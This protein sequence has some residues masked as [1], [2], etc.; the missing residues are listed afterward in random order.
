LGDDGGKIYRSTNYG[1]NWTDLGAIASGA[2]YFVAYLGNGIVV[3]GDFNHHVF[4]ST[5]YGAN[6]TDLGVI[7]SDYINV[8][9][10]MGNGIAVLADHAHHVYRSTNYGATWTDLGVIA[11]DTIASMAYLDGAGHVYCSTSAFGIDNVF[12][13]SPFDKFLQFGVL[14]TIQ[15]GGT[16]YPAPGNGAKQTNEIVI[17]V[18]RPGLLKNLYVWQRVASGAGGRTDIYTVRV[19]GGNTTIT[20]T[21]NN[22]TTGSDVT[23]SYLVAAGDRVSISL[24]SNNGSDTSADVTASVELV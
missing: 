8:I 24:V 3:F 19:N 9:V 17:R 15:A 22:A 11:G 2:I 18:P 6:W 21:L 10:Y 20:C 7:T 1:A 13:P 14:G 12:N 4:R 5:D 23:H 16:C